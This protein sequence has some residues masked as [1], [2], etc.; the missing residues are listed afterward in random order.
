MKRYSITL[1]EVLVGFTLFA[2]LIG[3][4]MLSFSSMTASNIHVSKMKEKENRF[5]FVATSIGKHF[6]KL[7]NQ[8]EK[9]FE[10]NLDQSAP[11]LT[12][13]SNGHID[14]NPLFLIRESSL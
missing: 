4:L 10:L 7:S 13:T 1:I 5:Q 6:D 12:F 2:I 14:R 3:T 11:Q 9:T 8:K